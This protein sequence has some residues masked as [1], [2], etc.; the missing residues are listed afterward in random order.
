MKTVLITGANQG[1]GFE[2]ARQVAKLFNYYIY[3]G[4]R[5]L[6]KGLQAVENLRNIFETNFFGAVLITQ[7]FIALLK[8]SNGPVIINISS[9][10]GSLTM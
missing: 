8:K 4:S 6:G 7:Q 1:I 2:T 5:N 10:L 9:P 3:L